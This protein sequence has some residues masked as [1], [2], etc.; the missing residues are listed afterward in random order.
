MK[1]FLDTANVDAIRRA[2]DTGLLDGVTTNPTKIMETGRPF[3]EVLKEICTIVTGPVSAEAVAVQADDI[4]SEALKI[5]PL[6]P[7]IAIKVP[8]TPEGLKACRVLRSQDIIVNATMIFSPDQAMLAMKAGV[9]IVTI[10]EGLFFD[11]FNHPL[12]D[13]GLDDFDRDWEKLT[14]AGL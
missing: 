4:V 6:A 12:T 3:R 14:S 11:M 8:M 1:L 5:K 10:A 2:N 7:N 13:Q 9:D